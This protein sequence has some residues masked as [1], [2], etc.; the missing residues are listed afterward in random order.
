M[1]KRISSKEYEVE[2]IVDKR[3]RKGA[4]EYLIKWKGFSK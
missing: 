1:P 2:D 3:V 4:V